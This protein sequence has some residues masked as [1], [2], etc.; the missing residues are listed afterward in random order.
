MMKRLHHNHNHHSFIEMLERERE[1]TYS[2]KKMKIEFWEE[3][4]RREIENRNIKW[5]W[6]VDPIE[7]ER[8]R[9]ETNER[10]KKTNQ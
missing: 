6:I 7:N 2:W 4:G 9:N 8:T 1:Y 3:K 5:E 10:E